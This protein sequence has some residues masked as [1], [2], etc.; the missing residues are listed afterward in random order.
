MTYFDVSQKLKTFHNNVANVV[1]FVDGCRSY[2]YLKT[3][4]KSISI[5]HLTTHPK[6]KLS[7]LLY[8]LLHYHC[9][10]RT[11]YDEVDDNVSF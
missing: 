1:K 6:R 5:N 10:S 9:L 3:T 2:C 8:D 4:K 7:P 11:D